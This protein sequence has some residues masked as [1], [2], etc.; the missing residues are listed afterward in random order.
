MRKLILAESGGTKTDWCIIEDRS[1]TDRFETIGLHPLQTDEKGWKKVNLLLHSKVDPE[2]YSLLFYGAGCYREEGK[3]ITEQNLDKFGFR[4][5]TVYSDL[6]AAGKALCGDNSGWVGI[7]GTGSV[8]FYFDKGD[9]TELIGGKG[10]LVGD[11]GSGYYFGKLLWLKA[12]EGKL[13]EQQQK[14]F[15]SSV[16]LAELEKSIEKGNDKSEFAKLS[17]I[18]A[19]HS[20]I[21]SN[22]HEE[23]IR[24]FFEKHIKGREHEIRKIS[25]SGGYAYYNQDLIRDVFGSFGV[26]VLKVVRKP[27]DALI[28]QMARFSD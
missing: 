20:I 2:E 1:V 12:K 17:E 24:L 14:V 28:E 22:I 21:F 26:S 25:L 3:N 18:L 10:H 15:H 27:I 5:F 23:N 9:I 19:D 11:E 7:M 4:K 8:L 6:H 16:D 13:S